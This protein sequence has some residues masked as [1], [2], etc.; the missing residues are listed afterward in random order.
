MLVQTT[1]EFGPKSTIVWNGPFRVCTRKAYDN[2]PGAAAETV[3]VQVM[4]V[5]RGAGDCKDGVNETDIAARLKLAAVQ[6]TKILSKREPPPEG[7]NIEIPNA[8]GLS[9]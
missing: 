7:G 9:A 3:E 1:E 2:V 8:R 4:A 5:P 6:R